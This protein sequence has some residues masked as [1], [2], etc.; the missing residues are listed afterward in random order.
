MSNLSR[1]INLVKSKSKNGLDK[2][3]FILGQG[4]IRTVVN[5]E[6]RQ[7]ESAL[8]FLHNLP[9]NLPF[10]LHFIQTFFH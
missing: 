3:K 9:H 1:R 10:F 7:I 4:V 8:S 5:F 6:P 2:A